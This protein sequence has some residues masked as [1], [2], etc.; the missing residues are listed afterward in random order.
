MKHTLGIVASALS[1]EPR[2]AV[3]RARQLGFEG[4]L[5]DAYAPQLSL[6]DLSQS[7]RREFRHLLS[8]QGQRLIGLRADLGPMGFS[9]AADVD[10]SLA[11]LERAVDAAA[12]LAAP[13]LCVDLGPLPEPARA[14]ARKP[15]VDPKDA[16]IIIIPTPAT[17]VPAE[18]E[19]KVDSAFES[20]VDSALAELGRH[21]DRYSVVLAMRSDLSSFAA[22][23]RALRAANCPWFGVDLDPVAIL[24]DAWP[25]DEIFSRVGALIRQVRVRDAVKGHDR[26][27]QPA[28][29]GKGST[30]WG[31]LL[32]LFDQAAYPGPLTVDPLELPDR[33]AAARAALDH[34]RALRA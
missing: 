10:K 5:F 24:R 16:G 30:I 18:P 2:E 25:A 13:L 21:A 29:V 22:L 6:P 11:R 14:A 8:A 28:T 15:T 3:V 23:D 9:P 26:R 12:G 1:T 20:S 17:V 31:E 34:L 4:L 27:T 33:I 32:A 19:V 7:G